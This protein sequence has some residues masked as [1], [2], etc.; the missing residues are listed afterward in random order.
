M[1]NAE[2]GFR[3]AGHAVFFLAVLLLSGCAAV[4]ERYR[5]DEPL[6]HDR[7]A[8]IRPGETTRKEVLLRF[9]PPVAVARR[10]TTMIFPPPGEQKRGRL[11]VPSEVFFELF[12]AKR[13]LTDDD[14]VYY[15]YSPQEKMAGFFVLLGGGGYTRR[16]AI[17]KVWF[18]INDRTGIVEDCR[19]RNED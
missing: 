4:W 17:E 15:Y 9:G 13:A 12:S 11:D 3:I 14:I 6:G 5:A 7:V 16:V 19:Y 1:K 8:V 18:L 10:G 2:Q